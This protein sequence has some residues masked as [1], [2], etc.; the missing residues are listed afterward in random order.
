LKNPKASSNNGKK[1]NTTNNWKKQVTSLAHMQEI[2]TK[3]LQEHASFGVGNKDAIIFLPPTYLFDKCR[4][5][6]II[7]ATQ[8]SL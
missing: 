1:M 5:Q 7:L 3:Q 4:W 6:T 2:C 8:K